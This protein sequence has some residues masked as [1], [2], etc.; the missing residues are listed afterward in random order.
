MVMASGRRRGADEAEVT[1]TAEPVVQLDEFG[2]KSRAAARLSA[3]TAQ[4]R[5]PR[6]SG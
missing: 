5:N 3:A 6:L 2:S 1:G 4:M